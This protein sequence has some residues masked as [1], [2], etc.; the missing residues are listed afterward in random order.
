VNFSGKTLLHEVSSILARYFVCLYV[1][2]LFVLCL[3][4]LSFVRSVVRSTNPDTLL[5][6]VLLLSGLHDVGDSCCD[7]LGCYSLLY[8]RM[9][10]LKVIR[11]IHLL[12][13]VLVYTLEAACFLTMVVLT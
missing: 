10:V 13:H 4:L 5:A 2:Y 9:R 8:S 12:L 6:I 11:N 1:F 3:F 7:V